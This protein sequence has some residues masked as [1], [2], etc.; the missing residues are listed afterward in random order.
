M[1]SLDCREGDSN[2]D[3]FVCDETSN[4]HCYPKE[5]MI[6]KNG[7]GKWQKILKFHVVVSLTTKLMCCSYWTDLL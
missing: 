6:F 4:K 3:S 7:K 5:E 1:A 2:G